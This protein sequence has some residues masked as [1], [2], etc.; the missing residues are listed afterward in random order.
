MTF[1]NPIFPDYKGMIKKIWKYITRSWD[2][3]AD[4]HPRLR[5]LPPIFYDVLAVCMVIG[6]I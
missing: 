2:S 6:I 5:L 4:T 1:L 3:E